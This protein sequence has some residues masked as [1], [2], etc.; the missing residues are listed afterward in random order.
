M[1]LH[2]IGAIQMSRLQLL[3][4]Q[5]SYTSTLSSRSKVKVANERQY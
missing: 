2:E 3:L 1:S 5:L 4:L